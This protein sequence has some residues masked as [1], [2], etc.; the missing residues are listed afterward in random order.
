MVNIH[1]SQVNLD[2]VST[3]K[4]QDFNFELVTPT[5]IHGYDSKNSLELRV[6]SINGMIRYWSRVLRVDS[7]TQHRKAVEGVVFGLAS[8]KDTIKGCA[9]LE[10][11][12]QT[13]NMG[14]VN[15][16]PSST[17]RIAITA[18]DES[19]K[20]RFTLRLSMESSARNIIIAN[21][22]ASPWN[23]SV[24]LIVISSIL[25]GFGQRGR[26]GLGSINMVGSNLNNKN[27]LPM[28]ASLLGRIQ[29]ETIIKGNIITRKVNNIQDG[30][31][32]WRETVLI[33]TR[34]ENVR[35]ILG[36]I[37]KATHENHTKYRGVLGSASPKIP[38]PL[39]TQIVQLANGGYAVL[40]SEVYNPNMR[41]SED[42]YE[43]S[44]EYYLDQLNKLLR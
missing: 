21:T 37:K 1:L 19:K 31:P 32:Y 8:D 23:Y 15:F 17:K 28:L 33:K 12:R 16:N 18:F 29:L 43:K 44:K 5:A 38:S 41:V 35:V 7:I 25:G 14:I 11:V 9:A 39:H 40:V 10:L 6:Q 3:K 2:K 24:A 30:A 20:N 34:Q 13:E 27:I 22:S 36:N 42:L 4:T 26:H